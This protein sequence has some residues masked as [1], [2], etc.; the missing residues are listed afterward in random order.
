VFRGVANACLLAHRQPDPAGPRFV[1]SG[2]DLANI[3]PVALLQDLAVD[4][5]LGI[6]SVERNGH[7]YFAGLSM[8]PAE[9]RHQVLAHHADLYHASR[10]GWPT[11][12]IE[13]GSIQVRSVVEAPFGFQPRLDVEQFAPLADWKRSHG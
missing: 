1:L 2:E 5:A 8:F 12:T 13:D 11:L 10:D 6:R 4:A 7:H 3:G 9:V